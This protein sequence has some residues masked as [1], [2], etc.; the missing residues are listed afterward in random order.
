MTLHRWLLAALVALTALVVAPVAQAAPPTEVFGGAVECEPVAGGVIECNGPTKTWDGTKVDVNVFLPPESL[1]EGPF[2]LIGDFHGWG[3][4]K[5]GLHTVPLEAPV[6][7]KA[8]PISEQEDPRIQKWAEEGYAV[9]SMSDRGWG[10][11][12]GCQRSRPQRTGMRTGLESPHGRSLR[13]P[14][15]PVPDV[16][17][18]R[19]RPR[20]AESHRR[21][22]RVLRRWPVGRPG[23]PAQSG[24]G[25]ERS[26]GSLG[27]PGRQ[28]DG[29]RRRGA[30][31][32]VDRP[33]L[34]FGTQRAQPRLRDQLHLQG[35]VGQLPDRGH[36][37]QLHRSPL[38]DG[39]RSR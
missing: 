30:A 5:Q 16:G 22:R 4:A 25:A 32:G 36:E 15:C 26:A 27:E 39:R 29:N 13:S 19:R 6:A 17:V 11:S 34:R 35:P 20:R 28:A 2:P 24:D 10:L 37:V 12:C 1:G 38:P 14:R 8:T 31:V 3:G 7:G 33:R 23:R 18:G 9:F 21:D